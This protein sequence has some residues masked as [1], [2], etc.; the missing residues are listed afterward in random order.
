MAISHD[1]QGNKYVFF[2][3]DGDTANEKFCKWAL[4]KEM[5]GTTYITRN[6]K[7]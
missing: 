4:T 5:K 1:F 7:A 6:S 2:S 3:D